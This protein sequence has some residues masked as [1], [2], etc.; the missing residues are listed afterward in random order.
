M[1]QQAALGVGWVRVAVNTIYTYVYIYIY[2]CIYIYMGVSK[3]RGGFPPKWMVYNG[4]KPYEQI[5]DLG[6]PLFLVQHPYVYIYIYV[7]SCLNAGSQWIIKINRVPFITMN[8]LFTH[9]EPQA[10]MYICKCCTATFLRSR[11]RNLFA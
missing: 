4:S 7:G 3:N 10:P 2:E 11:S 5:D 8:R 6:V 9:C 1:E